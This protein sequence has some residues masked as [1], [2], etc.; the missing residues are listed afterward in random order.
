M[1]GT[2]HLTSAEIMWPEGEMAQF[3]ASAA[4]DKK[5]YLKIIAKKMK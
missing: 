1:H 5:G 2:V 3:I 4:D